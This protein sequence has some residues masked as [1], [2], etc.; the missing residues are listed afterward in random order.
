[1]S[2]TDV[3][4]WLTQRTTASSTFDAFAE[5][6]AAVGVAVLIVTGFLSSY[7]TLR[8]L[9]VEV[10]QFPTW[11]AP[12]V[13]L[14]FDVGI[15]VLSLKV[16]LAARAGRTAPVLR[17]L[18]LTLSVTTVLANGASSPHLVGRLLHAV[19][20]AMFV[21]CFETLVT[22]ARHQALR[23]LGTDLT[24]SPFR[25]A[26]WLLAPQQTWTAWRADVLSDSIA[27]EPPSPMAPVSPPK[28]RA[29]RSAPRPPRAPRSQDS[30][31]DAAVRLLHERPGLSAAALSE[32]LTGDGFP[33]SVRTAN[34]VRQQ[35]QNRLQGGDVS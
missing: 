5:R 2:A 22:A 19:P 27:P 9:A 6:V 17:A 28:P 14:S 30:R 16:L 33:V 7:T 34:R 8:D 26:R 21:V 12:V 20:S 31:L 35:A 29:V 32:A 4:N 1:M 24:R 23:E 13:P 15:V 10:G 11:L 25:L 3:D 18:V